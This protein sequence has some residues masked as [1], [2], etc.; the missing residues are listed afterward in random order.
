MN[1]FDL[2]RRRC[3]AHLKGHLF[4]DDDNDDDVVVV[5]VVVVVVVVVVHNLTQNLTNARRGEA[6]LK[7]I[8]GGG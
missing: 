1:R 6:S 5:D 7:F 4:H 2:L 8:V 3:C